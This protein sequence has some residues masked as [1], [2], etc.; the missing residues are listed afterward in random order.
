MSSCFFLRKI[1][2]E[3][4]ASLEHKSRS[5][6][7]SIIPEAAIF[8][9]FKLLE[10]EYIKLCHQAIPGLFVRQNFNWKIMVDNF[11]APIFSCPY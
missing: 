6:V 5:L 10:S 11:S 4:A 7:E 9:S 2:E 3:W 8:D 1:Y